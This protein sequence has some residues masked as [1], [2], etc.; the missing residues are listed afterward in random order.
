MVSMHKFQLDLDAQKKKATRNNLKLIH[1]LTVW[2]PRK[3]DNDP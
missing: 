3:A 1:P 2:Y